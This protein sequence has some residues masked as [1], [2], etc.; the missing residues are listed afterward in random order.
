MVVVVVVDDGDAVMPLNNRRPGGTRPLAGHYSSISSRG[1]LIYVA[2]QGLEGIGAGIAI[3]R[4][5][6]IRSADPSAAVIAIDD[7]IR[8]TTSGDGTLFALLMD[9]GEVLSW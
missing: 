5:A 3:Y 4:E 2:G 8:L 9:A 7:S 6:D 1:D